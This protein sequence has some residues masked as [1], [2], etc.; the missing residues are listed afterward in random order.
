M[1]AP[2]VW[3]LKLIVNY[4]CE[5]GYEKLGRKARKYMTQKKRRQINRGLVRS[6]RSADSEQE[7]RDALDEIARRGLG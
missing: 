7:R 3:A 4:F 5:W 6:L 1:P 2:V